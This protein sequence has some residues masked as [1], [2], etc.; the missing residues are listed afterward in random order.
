MSLLDKYKVRLDQLNNG[1][2]EIYQGERQAIIE[3][4]EAMSR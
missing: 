3:V 1:Y 4:I 2:K